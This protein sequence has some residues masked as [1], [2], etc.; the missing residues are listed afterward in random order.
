MAQS[1]TLPISSDQPE[2]MIT[3]ASPI[4]EPTHCRAVS[5]C[6]RMGQE[7]KATA[8]GSMSVMRAT[9]PVGT[10]KEIASAKP[11]R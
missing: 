3:P 7:R 8:S 4:K 2:A 9:R 10:P 1:G 6:P 5:A 11:D